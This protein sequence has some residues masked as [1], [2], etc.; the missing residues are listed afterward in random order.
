MEKNKQK[1]FLR[2]EA[3]LKYLKG[4]DKLH[5]LVTAQSSEVDLITT[6]QNLY[7]ALGSVENRNE[8]NLNLLVKLL[9]VTQIVHHKDMLKEDRKILTPDRVE[10]IRKNIGSEK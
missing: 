10:E 9:E 8:I 2:P 5:T 7:E 1:M 6:D 4:D 3:I